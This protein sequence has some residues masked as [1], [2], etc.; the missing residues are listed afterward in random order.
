MSVRVVLAA[1]LAELDGGATELE[2]EGATVREVLHNL[3]GARAGL[4]ALLW[5]PAGAVNPALAVF[6]NDRMIPLDSGLDAP[7]KAGDEISVISALEGG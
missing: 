2:L 5:K 6:L 3:A 4:A 1:A 7:V